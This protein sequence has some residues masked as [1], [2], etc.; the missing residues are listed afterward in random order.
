MIP[1]TQN[2]SASPWPE[3]GVLEFD[4]LGAKVAA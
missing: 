3:A 1:A 4:D 2:Q